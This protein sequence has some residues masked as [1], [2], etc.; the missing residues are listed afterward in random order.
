MIIL[1]AIIPIALVVLIGVV[2][3]KWKLVGSAFFDDL[4]KVV[5]K[6]FVPVFLFV[7]V[8]ETGLED[9]GVTLFAYF[10]PVLVV[11]VVLALTFSHRIALTSTFS[12]NVLVG[13]PVIL[14]VAGQK[15][16]VISLAVISGH[17]LILFTTFF[18]FS[19]RVN[20]TPSKF[21]AALSI[22][23]NPVIIGVLLGLIFNL[24]DIP[25]PQ[26][27]FKPLEM[28]SD[29][30]LPLALIILGSSLASLGSINRSV[31]KKTLMVTTI[32][33]I[34]LPA[35][36]FSFGYWLVGLNETQLISLTIL[37]ACPTGI[38]V[39]PFVEAVESERKVAHNTIAL[40][41]LLS[42]ITIPT[43]IWLVQS[44]H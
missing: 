16:L 44:I 7:S 40:S 6:A 9:I 20:V 32:K 2:L 24:F 41:T 14:S 12:N 19:T 28:V 11:F 35:L 37:A 8:Y 26:Q 43:T 22:F 39:M 15:G 1:N 17:S 10:V 33:L 27:L 38:S 34:A 36:V 30:A 29:A 5:F 42:V 3:V 25:I 13:I 21:K 23:S 31:I 18:L 4:S